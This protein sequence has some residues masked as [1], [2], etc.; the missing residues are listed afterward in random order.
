MDQDALLHLAGQSIWSGLAVDDSATSLALANLR[1]GLAKML[2]TQ[3]Q[4][5]FPLDATFI[6]SPDFTTP[7][8]QVKWQWGLAIG[9][10]VQ[11]GDGSQPLVFLDPQVNTSTA[12]VA[13]VD[14]R[15][16]LRVMLERIDRLR[17]KQVV[18]QGLDME[19]DLG[20]DNHF[21]NVYQVASSSGLNLISEFVVI[22]HGGEAEVRKPNAL[23]W[24]LDYRESPP[25]REHMLVVD[26]P[27]GPTR[28]LT[29]QAAWDHYAGY[30]RYQNYSKEKRR[31]I[32]EEIFPGCQVIS[33]EHHHGFDGINTAL[34]G[35]YGFDPGL[36]TVYPITLR[37]DLPTYLARGTA[38]VRHD[39][40]PDAVPATLGNRIANANVLP[41]GGGY[42]YPEL[43]SLEEI[44]PG[45]TE[46]YFVLRTTSGGRRVT[47]DLTS[48]PFEYRGEPVMEMVRTW[49]LGEIVASLQPLYSITT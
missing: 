25:L 14:H 18:I 10:K 28:V 34:I 33:N 20:R 7:R 40:L 17:G 29:G 35:A 13:T 3:H 36:D 9:G 49:G 24:G 47:A 26:T 48:I 31:V 5:G 8:N 37:S 43:A 23:G 45:A 32:A 39:H 38:N 11:W 30:L 21:L 22:V 4:L 46:R 12:L 2:A 42:T 41:H 19:W 15:P 6:C 27:F 44:V 16:E 1:H